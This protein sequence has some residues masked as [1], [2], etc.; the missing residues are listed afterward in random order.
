[1]SYRVEI[2]PSGHAFTVE[3]GESVLDAALR[4]GFAFPYGCRNGACGSCLGKL[5]SGE[6]DYQGQHPPALQE[7]DVEAGRALFCQARPAGDLVIEVREIGAAKDIPIKTLPCR[8]ARM[9]RLAHDVM[10]LSLKLPVT[11]RLQ[12]LAGQ[13][14][15]ILL[16]DG[17]RRSFS[18]ANAPHD[19][20]FL[21]LHVR[22]VDGGVFSTHVFEQMKEKALLRIQGPLGAF[23]L[24]ED[25]DRPAILVGGGTGFAP[26]KSI[27]EHAFH[28]G[29]PRALHL[30]W[31]VRSR[32]DLYLAD[33]PRRWA[34]SQPGFHYTP[35]LSEPGPDDAWEGETGWVTDAVL[36]HYP[37]LSRH[38]VYVSGPPPMVEAAKRQFPEHGLA[39]EHLYY[40]SF[41][42]AADTPATGAGTR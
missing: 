11:E 40:D 33:L 23:F 27:L 38:D 25:S 2:Q 3:E 15:D 9:E 22:Q 42:Y 41:E 4:Q 7:A 17:R 35:V 18:L 6:V 32:Q 31:G 8:V 34:E 10:G 12:F 21:Q 30:F 14:V 36:R 16:R 24:R 5:V 28:L 26:L 29:E 39:F 1:M 13:Y 20:E 37:D 19:D